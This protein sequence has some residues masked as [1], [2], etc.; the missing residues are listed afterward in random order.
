MACDVKQLA[1]R[2]RDAALSSE[3]NIHDSKNSHVKRDMQFPTSFPDDLT[4]F[5]WGVCYH[6]SGI[7]SVREVC[8]L[9]RTE[10][11]SL[12]TMMHPVSRK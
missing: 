1:Y 2:L 12:I 11:S 8:T 6:D 10:I 4:A 3:V 7:V 5:F 9:G